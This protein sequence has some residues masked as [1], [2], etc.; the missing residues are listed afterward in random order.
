MTYPKACA[1]LNRQARMLRRI[2]GI[3]ITHGRYEYRFVYEG[4]FSAFVRLDR[5]PIGGRKYAYYDAVSAASCG[6]IQD[7]IDEFWKLIRGKE[8][9][10]T[11]V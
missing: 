1:I 2:N 10:K 11:C 9:K 5:R 7:V 4:G 8:A 6:S 3:R